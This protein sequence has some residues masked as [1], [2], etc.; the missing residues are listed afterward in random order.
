[1]FNVGINSIND[2]A[3]PLSYDTS[4]K[5][6]PPL[7]SQ[8]DVEALVDALAEGVID[9]IATD[10]APH[11]LASKQVTFQDASFGIS[12]LETALGSLMQLV[13]ENRISISTL[14]ERL[15]IGPARILGP[16]FAKLST[17]NAGTPADLVLFDPNRDWTVDPEEFASKGKNTPLVGTTFKGRVVATLVAGQVVFQRSE[18]ME[19]V[20]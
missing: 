9:C 19:Q 4:T 2:I 5:V 12:V 16:N 17:L 11:D 7:R 1:M 13:H 10:H 6:Y 15:T 3:G 20:S 14:I 18:L 8:H